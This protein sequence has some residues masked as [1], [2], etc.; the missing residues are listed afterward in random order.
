[1]GVRLDLNPFLS[2]WLLGLLCCV[3][4][5]PQWVRAQ[6]PIDPSLPEAPLPHKRA[7][8][9]LPGYDVVQQTTNPVAPLR[10]G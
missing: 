7:L 4:L 5:F 6:A 10:P 1:M 9:L 8:L 2:A 3:L